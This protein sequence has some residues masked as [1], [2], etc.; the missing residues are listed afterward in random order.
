M[1]NLKSVSNNLYYSDNLTPQQARVNLIAGTSEVIKIFRIIYSNNRKIVDSL[2]EAYEEMIIQQIK[3]IPNDWIKGCCETFY[4][5]RGL[6]L[7]MDFKKMND[8]VFSKGICSKLWFDIDSFEFVKNYL[9][10]TN[11]YGK[12]T[13][14]LLEDMLNVFRPICNCIDHIFA[15]PIEIM[16]KVASIYHTTDYNDIF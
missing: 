8:T 3:F 4:M 16:D 6:I 15:H 11:K 9:I 5:I 2:D 13:E 7:C 14:T 10:K 12:R 1:S